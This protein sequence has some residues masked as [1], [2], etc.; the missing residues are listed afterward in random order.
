MH[1]S[2]W[3]S[4]RI[5]QLGHATRFSFC[6]DVFE[7]TLKNIQIARAENA[8]RKTRYT[9]VV[10]EIQSCLTDKRINSN[11]TAQATDILNKDFILYIHVLKLAIVK[12]SSH[13]PCSCERKTYEQLRP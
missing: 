1:S 13:T 3:L 11:K 4:V 10:A 6:E 12:M 9:A 5:L 8:T 7:N 2:R